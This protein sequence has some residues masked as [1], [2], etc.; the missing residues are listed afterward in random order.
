MA[1][2]WPSAPFWPLL[3]HKF[4]NFVIGY[5]YFEGASALRQGRNTRSLLGS[6]SWNGFIIAVRLQ[7]S[8]G[9]IMN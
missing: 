6:P 3:V 7:F 8:Q 9:S 1:P 5:V 4:W 2:Y